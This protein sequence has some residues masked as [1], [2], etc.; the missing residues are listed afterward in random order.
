MKKLI[1]LMLISSITFSSVARGEETT[2]N[3]T[4]SNIATKPEDPGL[5][6]P[7][8]KGQISPFSGI[9]FSPRAAASVATD[10]ST[11]KDKIK[12]EVDAAVKSTEAKKDFAYNEL[13]TVCI[14]DKTK[15]NATIDSNQKK[16]LDLET[17][18]KKAQETVANKPMWIGF[19]VVGG[20][21]LTVATAFAISSVSK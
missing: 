5:L 4:V 1:A 21:V 15:L 9:L 8:N 16:I 13:N 14:S 2:K 18:L 17:D 6:A 20:I 12:I 11:L 19:G 7:L 3:T 10:L